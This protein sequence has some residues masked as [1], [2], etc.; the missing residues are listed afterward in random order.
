[1]R[2]ACPKFAL[3][4]AQRLG[5]MPKV[6]ATEADVASF[7]F[8]M[9]PSNLKSTESLKLFSRD[10]MIVGLFAAVVFRRWP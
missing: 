4:E 6:R 5:Q 1:M 10:T 8:E 9:T 7:V 3:A 2:D